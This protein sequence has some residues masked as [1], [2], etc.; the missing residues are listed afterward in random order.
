MRWLAAVIGFTVG[1]LLGAMLQ[2]VWGG[3]G[4]GGGVVGGLVSYIGFVVVL[5]LRVYIGLVPGDGDLLV[6]HQISIDG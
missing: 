5:Y 1:P 4:I 6:D 3:T 2:R